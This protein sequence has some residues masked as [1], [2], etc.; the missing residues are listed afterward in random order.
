MKN[1]NLKK[2]L[3]P[4]V[5]TFISVFCFQ[6][7]ICFPFI[8]AKDTSVNLEEKFSALV[9]QA[10]DE[11][12]VP[13]AIV[14]IWQGDSKPYIAAF[15]VSDI[16]SN[17]PI[18]SEH[19]MRIGSITKTFTGTVLLQLAD[20]G[21]VSLNDKLSMY[22]PGFP[23]GENITIENLGNMS[24]GIFNYTEDEN[25]QKEYFADMTKAFTPEQMIEIAKSHKPYF[26]PGTSLH[27]S[28]S[29]T[30]LLGLIIEKVTGNSLQSE[31]QKRILDPLRMTN[32]YFAVDTFFPGP[33]SR[34][35]MYEDSA[36][37]VPKDVTI[38][39]PGWGW[40]AGSMIS[41]IEDLRKYIKPLA[42][43]QLISPDAQ[44]ER[45]KWMSAPVSHTGVWKNFEMKYGFAIA[46]F[47]GVLG[48]NGGIPGFNSF[49]GYVPEKDISIIV[50]VNMQDNKEGIGPADYIA[51]QIID[52]IQNN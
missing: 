46:D 27:Y 42:A 4:S 36:S 26:S 22:F 21:K 43:G 45:L 30:I 5:L 24:S 40:A 37:M 1:I 14:G 47:N 9:K 13:G 10:F 2:I 49:A 12:K 7:G 11:M 16:V 34:G 38:L 33:H 15:G 51:R 3:F 31:I 52:G 39:N 41:T 29:N 6:C 28:N 23:N 19:K 8:D 48:H 32:S 20:E 35:Y 17:T 44:K 25:F 18:T 50:L